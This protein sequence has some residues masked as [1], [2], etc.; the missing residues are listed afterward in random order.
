MNTSGHNLNSNSL[1]I[2]YKAGIW[3]SETVEVN[4]SA[5]KI[6]MIF[7]SIFGTTT[8]ISAV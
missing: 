7:L 4:F 3:G 6:P 5:K 2:G 1:P 8:F